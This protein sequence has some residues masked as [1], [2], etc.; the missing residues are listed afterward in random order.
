[1]LT[2][3]PSVRFFVSTQ[4]TD[5]RKSFNGLIHATRQTLEQ[6]PLNGHVFVFF[7]RRRTM[8]KVLYWDRSGFCLWA[9]RLE[10]GAFRLPDW[11]QQNAV[12]MRAA[13]LGLVL[14]GLD[15]RGARRREVWVP[16]QAA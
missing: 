4:P 10:R 7:N 2:L 13:E 16:Q 11:Q 6:D 12:E 5:M 14:E 15:L 3:P 9:K 8:V 1:M